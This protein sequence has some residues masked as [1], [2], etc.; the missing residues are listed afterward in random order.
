MMK[1]QK[2]CRQPICVL[3]VCEPVCICVNN[4]KF[5]FGWI[6]RLIKNEKHV[7]KETYVKTLNYLVY[8]IW[9]ELY[10]ALYQCPLVSNAIVHYLI[11]ISLLLI[12]NYYY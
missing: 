4:W 2:D 12:I 11:I 8:F 7:K 3:W 6:N 10:Y 1:K 9:Y 5:V